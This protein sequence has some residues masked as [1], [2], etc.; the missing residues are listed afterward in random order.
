MVLAVAS[1]PLVMAAGAAVDY[2]NSVA[3]QARLQAA[4]DAAALA[5]GREATR[6]QAE[7]ERIAYDYF[8]SNYNAR[9]N[10]EQP[11]MTLSIDADGH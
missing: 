2:G 4:T 10:D 11:S 5:A 1:L 9:P 8:K 6:P 7:L 3:V